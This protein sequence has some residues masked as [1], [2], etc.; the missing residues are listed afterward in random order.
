MTSMATKPSRQKT[1]PAR[2]VGRAPYASTS[3]AERR[4]E[5]H[6]KRRREGRAPASLPPRTRLTH[7]F[8]TGGRLANF[9][10][11][12]VVIGWAS[13]EA[14]WRCGLEKG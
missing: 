1:E 9:G 14:P 11:D 10:Y 13:T 3:L 5:H 7:G 4:L 6:A 8:S 12:G 2:S